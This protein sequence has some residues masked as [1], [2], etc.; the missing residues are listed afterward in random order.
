MK[1]K[2]LLLFALLSFAT[3]SKAQDTQFWFTTNRLYGAGG[4]T[5]QNNGGFFLS[6]ANDK[7]ATVTFYYYKTNVTQT[8]TIPAKSG[9]AHVLTGTFIVN[10]ITT[11]YDGTVSNCGV[12]ITSSEK[13][14]IYFHWN[15][16]MYQY[17]A[18]LKGQAALGNEFYVTQVSDRWSVHDD[19]SYD[20]INIVATQD[21]TTINFTPTRD[22]YGTDGNYAAG[23]TYT[24]TLNRGQ[25]FSFRELER[26]SG[27]VGTLNSL[28]GTHIT[29]NKPIA[30]T[31]TEGVNHDP[32]ADQLIPV[33]RLGT[34]YVIVKG[35]GLIPD[36][37]RTY[38]TATR[39]NT[40][41]YTTTEGGTETLLATLNAGQTIAYN[42]GNKNDPPYVLTIRSDSPISVMQYVDCNQSN[43][44]GHTDGA[45]VPDLTNLSIGN[46]SFYN[47]FSAS[48]VYN[49]IL[50]VYKKGTR[51]DFT[52]TYNGNTYPI[53]V[54]NAGTI[55]RYGDVPGYPNLEYM[56]WELPTASRGMLINI[57]NLVSAYTLSYY[58]ASIS[59]YYTTFAYFSTFIGDERDVCFGEYIDPL[60]GFLPLA[61][62]ETY[63]WQLSLDNK[64]WANITEATSDTYIAPNNKRGTA[65]YRITTVKDG[66][67]TASGQPIKVKIR[68]CRL[69][70]NHN[71]SVMGYYD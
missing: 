27:L 33:T 67:I 14:S 34:D 57:N 16:S 66:V 59:T 69:P 61:N 8:I 21:G 46:Y 64:V 42:M 52:I 11:F 40:N 68:S 10:N 63:Q 28:A 36:G 31:S 13:V 51:E 39:D 48:D 53:T 54:S 25:T 49:V 55:V 45:V 12:Y 9:Y 5:P 7:A 17:I 71:I 37:E 19:Y 38:I 44:M 60:T 29:S 35:F 58:S 32:A 62:A 43:G 23:T 70:V 56:Q 3:I 47:I 1:Q 41:V 15:E 2:I 20:C 24:K 26:Y 18:T 65:Y 30:V 4:D 50:T 6:N 22:C